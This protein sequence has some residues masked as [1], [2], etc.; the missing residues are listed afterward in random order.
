M[1]KIAA[2]DTACNRYTYQ[3]MYYEFPKVFGFVDCCHSDPRV[4]IPII[5]GTIPLAD[6]PSAPCFQPE[7]ATSGHSL[8]GGT[9]VIV[10]QPT[11]KLP[12]APSQYLVDPPTYEEATKPQKCGE[13]LSE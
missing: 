7:I 2:N 5:I 8:L 10:Q 9:P 3:Y 13:F 1:G 12:T 4:E 6:V 11:P